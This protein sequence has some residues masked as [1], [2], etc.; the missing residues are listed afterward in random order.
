MHIQE[1][2]ESDQSLPSTA[3]S[4][5]QDCF[6]RLSSNLS[7][8]AAC[9][10][11][12]VRG[13]RALPITVAPRG[14]D[15]VKEHYSRLALMFPRQPSPKQA[16]QSPASYMSG[17]PMMSHTPVHS[18]ASHSPNKRMMSPPSAIPTAVHYQPQHQAMQQHQHQHQQRVN[19]QFNNNT[20]MYLSPH[21]SHVQIPQQMNPYML[22]QMRSQ[23]KMPVYPVSA[24]GMTPSPSPHTQPHQ[25]PRAYD[26]AIAQ[27]M[28]MAQ[29]RTAQQPLQQVYRQN[30]Q[31]EFY[32]DAGPGYPG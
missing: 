2:S 3:E 5:R 10:D 22:E 29:A 20:S 12:R 14:V 31:T 11:P 16:P 24:I 30:Y 7:F 19:A 13:R 17:T 18:R 4:E 28:A 21:V 26:P 27:Q 6:Q 8:L 9:A 1:R 15:S 23:Q 32:P 25:I